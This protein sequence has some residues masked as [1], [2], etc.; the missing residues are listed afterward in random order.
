SYDRDNYHPLG[1]RL[2]QTRVRPPQTQLHALIEERP[3]PRSF[4]A[5]VEETVPEQKERLLYSQAEEET[6]PYRWEFDLCN[7]TLGNFRYQKMSLVRDYAALL[8]NGREHPGFEGIFSLTPRPTDAGRP[9]SLPL[10]E[11][12]AIM[13][14][15]PTQASAIALAR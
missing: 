11:S 14:W 1:L 8:Q 10:E 2:F 15:D 7:V 5:P 4:M 6:N 12:Y 3:R 13:P 9:D